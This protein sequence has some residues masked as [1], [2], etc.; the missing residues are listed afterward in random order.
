MSDPTT[1]SRAEY[2]ASRSPID[3]V[4]P[5]DFEDAATNTR[6][7]AEDFADR[8]NILKMATDAL[9]IVGKLEQ[10]K[11]ESEYTW[12]DMGFARLFSDVF[13]GVCRYNTTAKEWYFYTGTVWKIDYGHVETSH[14]GKLLTTALMTYSVGIKDD[15]TRTAYV[16]KAAQY[17]QLKYRETMIKDSGCNNYITAEMLDR[18]DRYFNCQNG[19]LDLETL[20][21]LPHDPDRLL[22]K[23]SNVVYDPAARSELWE[24]TINEIMEADKE[25]I[26]YLQRLFGY[27]LTADTSLERMWILYGPTARNGKSTIVETLLYLMGGDGGYGLTMKPESL[28]QKTLKDGSRANEDIARLENCRMVNASEPEKRINLNCSLIKTLIGRDT[29][30]TR[31]LYERT[32]QFTPKFK[33]LLNTNHLPSVTD[34]TMF[35]GQ[36]IVVI[37]FKRHFDK[38]EQDLHLKDKLRTAENVSGVFNWCLEGLKKFKE[39]GL[40]TPPTI[41][42]AI[43]EY[44]HDSDKIMLFF[45]DCMTESKI[46]SAVANVYDQYSSWCRRNNRQPEG[47]QGFINELN[48]RGLYKKTGTINGKTVRNVVAGW[49][50]L[51]EFNFYS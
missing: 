42:A 44:E 22:S 17:G 6:T 26:D 16:K 35:A 19:T 8:D 31:N 5:E 41:Q 2:N 27:C 15:K 47:K 40:P 4:L 28:A 13:G 24:N 30:A 20:Q 11:P 3:G 9:P 36:K 18:E 32:R 12:D 37:E 38:S 14:L 7:A 50:L 39:S 33:L 10:L 51:P 49:E 23:I 43:D 48:A 46:N 29:V 1:M 34:L 45:D 25:K 21:L